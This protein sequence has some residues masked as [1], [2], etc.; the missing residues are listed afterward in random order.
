MQVP[1]SPLFASKS[2]TNTLLLGKRRILISNVAETEL[3]NA[4][5]LCH[6]KLS[7]QLTDFYW[8]DTKMKSN[9]QALEDVRERKVVHILKHLIKHQL[10]E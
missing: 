10:A 3:Q 4:S 2:T 5:D 6:Y 9:V 1:K 7:R 8:R